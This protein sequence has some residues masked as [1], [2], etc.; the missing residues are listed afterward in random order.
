MNFLCLAMVIRTSSNGDTSAD[1]KLAASWLW[2]PHCDAGLMRAHQM[3]HLIHM[4]WKCHSVFPRYKTTAMFVQGAL[5]SKDR[6]IAKELGCS[7]PD[8]KLHY[9]SQLAGLKSLSRHCLDA[10]RRL[11]MALSSKLFKQN[12][13]A[14]NDK[15]VTGALAFPGQQ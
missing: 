11:R 9:A 7:A 6:C 1:H 15:Y 12:A 8:T 10:S 4:V 14:K 2:Q 3:T 5:P 13:R